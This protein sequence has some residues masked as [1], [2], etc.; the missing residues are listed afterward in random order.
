[1]KLYYSPG[2]CSLA[3]DIVLREAKLKADFVKVD[4][5]SKKTE[6]GDDFNA[7]NPKGYVPALQLDDGD[8]LTE[9]VAV[10]QYLATLEPRLLPST[11]M[12]KWHAVESL[13]FVSTEIHKA[14]KPLFD[15]SAADDVKRKA[16]E[17]IAKRLGN[18]EQMLGSREHIVG[19]AFTVVDAYL[20]VMLMWSEKQEVSIP[21][22]LKK[23]ASRL[24]ERPSV[25]EALAFEGLDAK[26]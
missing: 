9:N 21:A 25:K 26:G 7:V 13:A 12:A 24:R 4:L 23:Y 6:K 17:Q 5:E 14:F 2:A 11:G 3:T 18:A 19:D 16:K 22:S 15:R 1:M 10:L 20:F 8:V